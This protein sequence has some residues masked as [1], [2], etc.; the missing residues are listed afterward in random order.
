MLLVPL[1]YR[2]GRY[3]PLFEERA[4]LAIDRSA[5][6]RSRQAAAPRR[7]LLVSIDGLGPSL[8]AEVPTPFL[9][10]L[11][12]DGLQAEAVTTVVP[13]VTLTSHAS[14]LS[15]LP[16][17][18]HGVFF[19]RVEPWREL[20]FATIYTDCARA[21]LRCGLFAGKRK[22]VHFAEH[23]PGVERYQ[24]GANA[25]EVLCHALRYAHQRDP[26]FLFVHLAEVDLTGHTEGWGSGLQARALQEIDTRLAAFVAVLAELPR[27]LV[28]LVTSEHG[29]S[30]TSHHED[31]PANREIPWILW[32]DGVTTDISPA[33]STLDTYTAL[34]GFLLRSAPGS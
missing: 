26:D 19:N 33:A 17:E 31:T 5:E 16:P 23:E 29:G 6:G 11:A 27:P 21:R 7:V 3:A 8:L 18:E 32:G 14:M 1:L 34:Q 9:D 15:G 22:F 24:Y 30:G 4:A 20:R 28:V 10:R 2:I 13:P 25:A 12:A